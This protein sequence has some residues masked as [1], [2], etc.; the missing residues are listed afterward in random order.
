MP[1]VQRGSVVKRPSG[2]GAARWYDEAGKRCQ[3]GGF[4]TRSEALAFLGSKVEEVVALRRGDPT[5]LRRR[6]MLT[7]TVLVD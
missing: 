3:Q 2:V 7:L 5:A 1:S 4:E 6:Q